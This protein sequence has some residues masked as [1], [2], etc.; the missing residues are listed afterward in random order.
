MGIFFIHTMGRRG[1][2][3]QSITVLLAALKA[4]G[5]NVAATAR[6]TGY[7]EPTIRKYR[8]AYQPELEPQIASEESGEEARETKNDPEVSIA[9][10]AE[11]LATQ[12]IHEEIHRIRI[13]RMMGINRLCVLIPE[14][15]K[16]RDIA[17][18]VRILDQMENERILTGRLNSGMG[19]SLGELLIEGLEED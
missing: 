10:R 3:R 8:A 14:S 18:V 17:G 12:M 7:S 6:Q 13:V 9:R 5:G 4:N 1:L 15:T 19:K 11:K 16:I 2:N